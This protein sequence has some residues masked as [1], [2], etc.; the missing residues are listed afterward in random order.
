MISNSVPLILNHLWQSTVF[1]AG[2]GVLVLFLRRAQARTRY[3]LWLAGS[4]KFLVPFALFMAAGSRIHWPS[5]RAVVH[6]Q[7]S[8]AVTQ[9]SQPFTES[10]T[11]TTGATAASTSCGSA[12]A[13]DSLGVRI[14]RR[15]DFVVSALAAYSGDGADGAASVCSGA[16]SRTFVCSAAGAFRVWSVQTRPAAAGRHREASDGRAIGSSLRA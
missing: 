14:C 9:A 13:L 11:W 15:I 2:M 7:W 16:D 6:P 3:G 5:A 10:V 4:L 1:A 12:G 8:A